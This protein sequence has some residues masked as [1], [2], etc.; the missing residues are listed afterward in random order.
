MRVLYR[1]SFGYLRRHPWQ[2]GLA[3]LGICIGVAVMV[4]VDLANESAR[5]AFLLSMDAVNGKATHQIVAGPA[6]VDETL[7]AGLRVE[8]GI[9]AIAPIVEGY[10][11]I[12]DSTML[13]LGVDVFAERDFRNYTIRSDDRNARAGAGSDRRTNADAIRRLLTVP[14]AV[15][16]SERTA[17]RFHLA[18][19]RQ[20]PIVA[21]GKTYAAVLA[22][23]L[24]VDSPAAFDNLVITDIAVAQ[25]W[26]NRPGKLTRIDVRIPQTGGEALIG[27]IRAALPPDAHL[28]NAERRTRSV[29][30]MSEAF[31]TNLTAMSLL[32]LLVGLFLIYNSVGFAVLQR[33]GLIGVL[34]ALG[35]TRRE[36][37]LLILSEALVLG[38]IGAALGVLAGIWLGDYLLALVSRSINDLY[39]VVNVT[40]V[41]LSP[42]S[43]SKG[44]VAGL[45]ATMLAAGAPA[46][47]ASSYPPRLALSRSV[48]EHR[49]GRLLPLIAAA[50]LGAAALAIV[51]LETSGSNLVAGLTALFLLI[52]GLALCIPI[53]SRAFSNLAAPVG[54]RL[55][56]T[57]A[58]LAVSGIGASLSRSGVAIVALAVAVSATVGVSVM[59]DSFR[60]SVSRWLGNTLQADIYVGVRRGQLDAGLIDALIHVDGVSDHS[61]RRSIWLE[62]ATERTRIIALQMSSP[63]LYT[64][65]ILDGDPAAVWRA[66]DQEGA[67]LVSEPYAYRHEV[68][69]GD[70]IILDTKY[71]E[72]HFRVAAVYQSYDDNQGSVLMRRSRYAQAFGDPGIDSI[73]LYLYPQVEAETVIDELRRLADGRQAILV[74]SNR[75]LLD[76]SLQIFD[77]TFIIT[78]VL[79]W[80]A[81]GVAVIGTLG[82]MLAL[83]LE[84]A[85][86]LAVLRALGMT[87]AQI[88]GMVT[89]QS[90]F[91]GLISGLAAMPLGLVMAAVLILVINRRA[92]G[93]Q[94]DVTVS[95]PVL[96]TALALAVGAALVA[97]LYPAWRAARARPALAMR[98]E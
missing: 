5:K 13:L 32:A 18:P 26:L 84:R 29:T 55:G 94:M 1:A 78:D 51:L 47:E 3:L 62:S 11:D 57:P 97:G 53:A 4:A 44:L 82:A 85:R 19:D 23:L 91:I 43:L 56:G 83:Q 87:P 14:G 89:L 61:T 41:R 49:A 74:R 24:D 17:R 45:G 52:L 79:Y 35:V 64:T 6:G 54:A 67:V 95:V 92:F 68:A 28:L 58:R 73:G 42:A 8:Q 70:D 36:I 40:D 81:V 63:A 9:G 37:C 60:D 75:Q 7:Y 76:Q 31:M 15:L 25:E 38:T 12:G 65:P 48:L 96:A 21:N 93:W 71:G 69:R 46:I 20:F 27:R 77:R 80:L 10:I 30:D 86:E 66:F 2:L 22:G 50:G 39:F 16:A 90:G 34:R 88:A 72:R 33:R 98:E 59:V